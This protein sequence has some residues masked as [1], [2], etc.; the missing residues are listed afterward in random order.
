MSF[1]SSSMNAG[2]N[3]FRAGATRGKNVLWAPLDNPVS[4]TLYTVYVSSTDVLVKVHNVRNM[5]N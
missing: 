3:L 1:I 4:P 5:Y 2:I